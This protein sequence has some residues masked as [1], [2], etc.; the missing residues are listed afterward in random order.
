MR[1]TTHRE[2]RRGGCGMN[3]LFPWKRRE[4]LQ[5]FQLGDDGG[6][7]ELGNGGRRRLRALQLGGEEKER[8]KRTAGG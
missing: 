1:V 4:G 6:D 5:C 2:N 7:V 8:P 3:L